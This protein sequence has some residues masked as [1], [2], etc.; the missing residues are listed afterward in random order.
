[1]S[2]RIPLGTRL[3]LKLPFPKDLLDGDEYEPFMPG[4]TGTVECWVVGHDKGDPD[5]EP[6]Y[7][8]CPY[9]A[10]RTGKQPMWDFLS[11]VDA[12]LDAGTAPAGF[13]FATWQMV[14]LLELAMHRIERNIPEH[15]L[16]PYVVE[17]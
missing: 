2:H 15:L 1:M 6:D 16:I 11:D 10:R 3:L 9:K 12:H 13:N 4:I 7:T 5:D 8:I 14:V 17:G